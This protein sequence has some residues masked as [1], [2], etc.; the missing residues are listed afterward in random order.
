MTSFS[1]F[2]VAALFVFSSVS[3]IAFAESSPIILPP[4][5][6]TNGNI[7][8]NSPI[9]LP[10]QPPTNGNIAVN[11]PIILPPQPPTNGGTI[12]AA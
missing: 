12:A 3:A 4:Q 7:A 9:I 1:T 11:S 10:P 6:P 5:P 8:V 2:R